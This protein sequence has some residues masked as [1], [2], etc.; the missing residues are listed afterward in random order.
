MNL[1]EVGVVSERDRRQA[2]LD[3]PLAAL[4]HGAL[5]SVIGPLGVHVEIRRQGHVTRLAGGGAAAGSPDSVRWPASA[6][7]PERRMVLWP[8]KA[9]SASAQEFQQQLARDF[10]VRVGRPP[11]QVLHQRLHLLLLP[12]R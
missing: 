2:E 10:R 8:A 5:L 3:R 4:L 6:H 12:P 1:D 11:A 7:L 9:P